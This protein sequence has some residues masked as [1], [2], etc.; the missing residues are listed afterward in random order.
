MV[1]AGRSRVLG[2]PVPRLVT[3][4]SSNVAGVVLAAGSSS[5]FGAGQPKQLVEVAGEALVRRVCRVAL[6]SRLAEVVVVVGHASAAVRASLAG[7]DLRVTENPE[8][9]AGQSGSVRRGLAAIRAKATAALFLVCDQPLL[10]AR[11]LDDLIAAYEATGGPIVVATAG[12]R[13]GSP[14][15]F[16]RELFAELAGITGDRGGRQLYDRHPDGIV[17]V[18]IADPLLLADVDTPSELEELLAAS[19]GRRPAS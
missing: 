11:V 4:A 5:R 6:S 10:T 14:V 8:W 9:A 3:A 1:A 18:P 2:R 13:R 7:L 12:E 17:E 15:L 19:E 16:G